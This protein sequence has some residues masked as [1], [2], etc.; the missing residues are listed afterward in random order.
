ML[1]SSAKTVALMVLKGKALGNG[2]YRRRGS[3]RY[4]KC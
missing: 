2:G 4:W 3:T 1:Q